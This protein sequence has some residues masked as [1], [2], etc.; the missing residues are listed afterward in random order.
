MFWNGFWTYTAE[1]DVT[2]LRLIWPAYERDAPVGFTL[3]R[4]GRVRSQIQKPP[5][6]L[7]KYQRNK[8]LKTISLFVSRVCETWSHSLKIFEKKVGL[9]I[10][11]FVHMRQ[12]KWGGGRREPYNVKCHT[13][14][15]SKKYYLF[16]KW[17]RMPCTNR[18]MLTGMHKCGRNIREIATSKHHVST[19]INIKGNILDTWSASVDRIHIA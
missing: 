6:F 4:V 9:L 11:T 12:G 15:S 3:W 5:I 8:I 7:L 1:H 19:E 13:L 16:I 2:V 18:K 14:Y 17:N 10:R